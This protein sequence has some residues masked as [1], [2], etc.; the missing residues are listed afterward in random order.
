MLIDLNDKEEW[1]YCQVHPYN[2]KE[3]K[4]LRNKGDVIIV[5]NIRQLYLKEI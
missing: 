3:D 1:K 4:L 2:Y 5:D